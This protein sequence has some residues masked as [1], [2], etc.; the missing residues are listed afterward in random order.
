MVKQAEKIDFD[1]VVCPRCDST[2]CVLVSDNTQLSGGQRVGVFLSGLAL[3]TLGV[4]LFPIAFILIFVIIGL[5]MMPTIFVMIGV[6]GVMMYG[7]LSHGLTFRCQRCK[8]AW[9]VEPVEVTP[10]T[11]VI[12]APEQVERGEA[13][14]SVPLNAL[15]AKTSGRQSRAKDNHSASIERGKA[16]K[17]WTLGAKAHRQGRL[18][19]AITELDKAI[20]LSRKHALEARLS[21]D[22]DSWEFDADV[23]SLRAK[24]EEQLRKSNSADAQPDATVRLG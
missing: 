23:R 3:L 13:Y 10:T 22:E 1:K 8:R 2:D 5:F 19:D 14:Q 6:G 18:E 9:N 12:T 11:L 16:Y 7:A 4:L 24:A 17:H 21:P 20:D 15:S